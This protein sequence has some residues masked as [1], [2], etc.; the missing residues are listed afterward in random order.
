MS[1]RASR[2][3]EILRTANS[4]HNH[5]AGTRLQLL[6]RA[7]LLADEEGDRH[8][9]IDARQSIIHMNMESNSEVDLIAAFTWLLHAEPQERA[10][11]TVLW[12]YKWVAEAL[13]GLLPIRAELVEQ[14]IADLEQA[15][16]LAGW[17]RAAAR[18]LRLE[19]AITM[20]QRERL[21]ALFDA[22]QEDESGTGSDCAACRRHKRVKYFAAM[23]DDERVV[24]ESE[25]FLDGTL[26]CGELP[27]EAFPHVIL[28]LLRLGRVSDADAAYQQGVESLGESEHIT[29]GIG[30]YLVFLAVRGR[31]EEGCAI[32][33]TWMRS[34]LHTRNDMTRFG[35]LRGAAL[36]FRS[37]E[38]REE[39]LLHL[40]LPP[41][42]R[43]YEAD[44]L[45]DVGRL[46]EVFDEEA[47]DLARRFDRRHGNTGLSDE[48]HQDRELLERFL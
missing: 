48:L 4:G 28:P 18:Q 19:A 23:Q 34:V 20:R 1:W 31:I 8:T 14:A 16:A 29:R 45:Y 37:A 44:G 2:A 10:S 12:T 21:P 33:T 3:R 7:A 36:L 42:W 15:Y 43:A 27:R 9:A 46:S 47:A 25:Q 30:N 5:S 6:H 38:A 39:G 11:Y 13:A 32:L 22:W 40:A 35:F 26:R 24:S 17:S 41:T